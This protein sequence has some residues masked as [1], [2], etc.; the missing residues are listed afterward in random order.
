MYW[1]HLINESQQQFGEYNTLY[2]VVMLNGKMIAHKIEF[3]TRVIILFESFNTCE[4]QCVWLTGQPNIDQ[5]LP[6]LSKISIVNGG[7]SGRQLTDRL[8]AY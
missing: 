1:V 3:K 6:Q 7:L 4:A 8:L 5:K 2:I